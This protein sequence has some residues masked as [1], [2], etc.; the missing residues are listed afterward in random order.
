MEEG[1]QGIT[2]ICWKVERQHSQLDVKMHHAYECKHSL[3]KQ[4]ISGT[5]LLYWNMNINCVRCVMHRGKGAAL[6]VYS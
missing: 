1:H 6:V 3:S 5:F 4:N 2:H